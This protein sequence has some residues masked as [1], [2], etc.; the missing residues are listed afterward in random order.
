MRVFFKIV[1]GNLVALILFGFLAFFFFGLTFSAL[2]MSDRG[3]TVERNSVLIFDMSVN[4]SDA[5]PAAEFMQV[6][7]QSMGRR[8]V[9][10]HSLRTVTNA[11]RAAANDKR[12]SGLFLHGSFMPQDYGTG[13]SALREVRLAVEEFRESGKPV[14]AYLENPTVREYYVASAA[15][16]IVLNPYGVVGIN[17]LASQQFF[18]TGLL[19]KYGIGV[20]VTR[21]GRYKSAIELFTETEMSA[22]NRAQTEELLYDI[23]NE[24]L[25]KVSESRGIS[26]ADLQSLT[27]ARGFIEPKRAVEQGLVDRVGYFD[28]VMNDVREIAGV[29]RRTHF[30]Q[31][32][33]ENYSSTL[34]EQSPRRR[35][36]GGERIAIIY[37]EGDIVDGEGHPGSV[38]GNRFAREIRQLRMNGSV[39][40]IVVRV[41][42][43]G[44]SV[45]AAE[46]IQRELALAREEMPVIVSCGSFAASGG[47]WVATEADRIFA[48]PNTITGSIGVFGILPNLQELAHRHGVTFD[49]VRTGAFADVFSLTRPKTDQE[50]EIIQE[51]VDEIYQD[52]VQRVARGRDMTVEQADSLAQGRIWSGQQALQ[53]GLVD[54]IGGLHDAIRHA[55]EAAGLDRWEIYEFPRPAE[56]AEV[57]AELLSPEHRP[58]VARDPLQVFLRDLQGDYRNLQLL[59]DPRGIYAR[60]PFSLRI[61]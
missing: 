26:P 17:G 9:P 19:E 16:T 43:P 50:M 37:M 53:N 60:L 2:M 46:T 27:D 35:R 38:G 45:T 36:G 52:F 30:P 5:P 7:E 51:V 8:A 56:F 10:T 14:L 48:Q 6:V 49:T 55:G 39:S 32:D 59:N 25:L 44:G 11:I 58:L 31:I 41:N 13:F 18:L 61:Q 20:Q 47:Y 57:L 23:W 33:I 4:I 54:E 40:A 42:S 28:E 15:E 22:D 1:L 21:A 3:V 12:V 29:S 24:I 34:Q